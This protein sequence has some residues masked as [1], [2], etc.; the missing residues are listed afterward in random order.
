MTNT[1]K[2]QNVCGLK[3]EDFQTRI[4]GKETDL[5]IL[6]NEVGN[7]VAITNYSGALVAIMVPDKH[8]NLSNVIQGHDNI[9]D[10][11]NSPEPYLS[12]LVGR[13]GNK[14]AAVD[15]KSVV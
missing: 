6:R 2:V 13:Y 9:Q 8:G 3:R 7:E 14:I 4:D 5:Y 1:D 12:T 10:V 11:V 15:R